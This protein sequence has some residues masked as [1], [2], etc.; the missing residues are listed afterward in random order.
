MKKILS[1]FLSC[2]LLLQTSLYSQTMHP[3]KQQVEN[4]YNKVYDRV[5]TSPA[6]KKFKN[7]EKITPVIAM[8]AIADVVVDFDT[9][10]K[11]Q[12]WLNEFNIEKDVHTPV[13]ELLEEA[14]NTLKIEHEMNVIGLEN[15]IKV[16]KESNKLIQQAKESDPNILRYY[17]KYRAALIK[18]Q[19]LNKLSINK[20]SKDIEI[21][22]AQFEVACQ[23]AKITPAQF[24]QAFKNCEE[25][26]Y[27]TQ[28]KPQTDLLVQFV[29]KLS[30]YAGNYDAVS[31][32]EKTMSEIES[33]PLEKSISFAVESEGSLSEK[34]TKEYLDAKNLFET[35]N[36]R[37]KKLI[38]DY[39]AGKKVT[40]RE[41]GEL[42]TKVEDL[43]IKY[44]RALGR[45]HGF[46]N[47]PDIWQFGKNGSLF[48][49]I[50]ALFG[51]AQHLMKVQDIKNYSAARNFDEFALQDA[52]DD[53]KNYLF[54]FLEQLPDK[55]RNTA[56]AYI[57][58]NYF[59]DFQNQTKNLLYT[60]A[61]LEKP[62]LN[63]FYGNNQNIEQKTSDK[64][65]KV[66]KN[67]ETK[68]RHA[69]LNI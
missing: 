10:E 6:L 52:I 66:Y 62:D 8:S 16:A 9:P 67:T 36:G 2:I 26:L 32:I 35:E 48:I 14:H 40:I 24:V 15:R 28:N 20:I 41:V 39:H 13:Y 69:G 29:N 18:K 25:I 54:G 57:A 33:M 30:F 45:L 3:T 38:A 68:I 47:W 34:Y 63:N 7:N 50:L 27:P 60:L 65:D 22:L 21:S 5:N 58:E 1:C 56:F 31:I 55:E 17:Y 12:Y 42:T 37:L 19:E 46:E 49:G 4:I 43:G 59:D 11:L 53:N 23:K 64:F 61:V 44:F 51:V